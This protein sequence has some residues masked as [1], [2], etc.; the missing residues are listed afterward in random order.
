LLCIDIFINI[1]NEKLDI[2]MH[3]I[4]NIF[5][6]FR[7]TLATSRMVLFL[8]AVNLIFSLI[9]TIPMYNSIQD[10][11]GESLSR[12][13]MAAGFDYIWWEEF[14]DQSSGLEKNI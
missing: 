7:I 14:R 13:R 2:I 11:L 10:S 12:D 1:K 8:F 5:K 3:I 6:G 4:I 9:L